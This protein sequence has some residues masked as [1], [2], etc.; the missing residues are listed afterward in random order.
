MESTEAQIDVCKFI[1]VMCL[2]S[3]LSFY[4][5]HL[6]FIHI[7]PQIDVCIHLYYVFVVHINIHACVPI[8]N[9]FVSWKGSVLM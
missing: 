3:F 2:L 7:G 5:G 9:K 6:F 1:A 4:H 8:T